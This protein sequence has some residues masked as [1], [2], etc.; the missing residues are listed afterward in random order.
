MFCLELG[1]KIFDL[2]ELGIVGDD[3]LH[4]H[5]VGDVEGDRVAWVT[6][7]TKGLGL[8]STNPTAA[9]HHRQLGI[10]TMWESQHLLSWQP[11][12]VFEQVTSFLWLASLFLARQSTLEWL[13]PKPW[14]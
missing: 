11:P 12:I 4:A 1:I 10:P 7:V 6:L 5:N 3:G 2:G 13:H 8:L 14:E 9:A